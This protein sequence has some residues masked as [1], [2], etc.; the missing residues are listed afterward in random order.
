MVPWGSN[1][2]N[3]G[4]ERIFG[5]TGSS[6]QGVWRYLIIQLLFV[7]LILIYLFIICF[8]K[9]FLSYFTDFIAVFYIISASSNFPD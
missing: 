7:F 6:G 9:H 2:F 4:W 8:S 5:F 1:I 3:S